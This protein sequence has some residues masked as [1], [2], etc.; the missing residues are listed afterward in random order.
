MKI[1]IT[2]GAGSGKTT[3][4]KKLSEKRHIPHF[5][6]DKIKWMNGGSHALFNQKRS[7]QKNA[8]PY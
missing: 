3:Y 1:Y 2:G 8:R 5:D 6:L 4:A 7:P